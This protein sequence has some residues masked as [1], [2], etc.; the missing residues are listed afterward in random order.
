MSYDELKDWA[1]GRAY[2]LANQKASGSRKGNVITRSSQHIDQGRTRRKPAKR[3]LKKAPK[4]KLKQVAAMVAA[5]I[6]LYAAGFV[7]G[8]F[9]VIDIPSDPPASYAPQYPHPSDA[10]IIKGHFT[11]NYFD[12]INDVLYWGSNAVKN[13]DSSRE[14][15][16]KEYP[17]SE[18]IT[19]QV[20]EQ[21]Q[22]EIKEEN[23]ITYENFYDY[24]FNGKY[25][26][27]PA[28]ICPQDVIVDLARQVIDDL[29]TKMVNNGEAPIFDGGKYISYE[30]MAYVLTALCY[31]ESSYVVTL[32][33]EVL[34]NKVNGTNQTAIG[35]H[36]QIEKYVDEANRIATK[37]GLEGYSYKD[38]EDPVKAFEM[39]A[40][41]QSYFYATYIN[42]LAKASVYDKLCPNGNNSEFLVKAMLISHNAPSN[43]VNWIKNKNGYL[44]LLRDPNP[45]DPSY[46]QGYLASAYNAYER[47]AAKEAESQESMGK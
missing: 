17:T 25:G 42:P 33:G 43:L 12:R 45:S 23:R 28:L 46:G 38:R 6:T 19:E 44:D 11:K 36:Q 35:I 30:E 7:A 41:I 34:A 39:T 24:C 15:I 26:G 37:Y 47:I 31:R 3:K 22:E 1:K 18:V 16:Q 21:V 40:L 29:N 27:T 20:T 5:G 8:R 9:T 14:V 13:T 2:E 10:P 32:N 4:I